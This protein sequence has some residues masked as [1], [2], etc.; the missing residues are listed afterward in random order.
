[1]PK[2]SNSEN[3]VDLQMKCIGIKIRILRKK[4]IQ[5]YEKWAFMHDI[6]KVTL[7]RVERGENVTM[8]MLLEII[9][10]LNQTPEVFFKHIF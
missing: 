8:K 3:I 4:E 10:E 6:N 2:K 5:N 7:N 1:M 9:L